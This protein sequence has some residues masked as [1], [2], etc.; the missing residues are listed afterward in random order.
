MHCDSF[1]IYVDRLNGGKVERIQERLPPDFLEQKS[2]ELAYNKEV[3]VE[4]EA[5]IADGEL[6]IHLNIETTVE[7]PCKI[8]N[9]RVELPVNLTGIYIVEPV[10][11]IKSGIYSFKNRLREAIL[12]EAPNYVECSNGRCPER[13]E[14]ERYFAEGE[15]KEKRG[16]EKEDGYHP[17]AG[18]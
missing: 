2:E 5:Y 13:S 18:L 9:S 8:C 3:S 1:K 7:L 4:G 17:F 6:I 16:R 12:L 10:Q 14:Q 15:A 11:S